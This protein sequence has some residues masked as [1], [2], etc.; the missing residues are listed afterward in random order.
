LIQS[1]E[2][3][4]LS[5]SKRPIREVI[6]VSPVVIR[7]E[8]TDEELKKL[9]SLDLSAEQLEENLIKNGVCNSD[10]EIFAKILK[11]ANQVAKNLMIDVSQ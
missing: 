8:L 3:E 2:I 7:I 6:M 9:R 10:A 4:E 1:K 11:A 5:I